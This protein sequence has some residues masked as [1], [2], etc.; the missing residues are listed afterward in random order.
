MFKTSGRQLLVYSATF[1]IY[2][3]T[4]IIR[5]KRVRG[6]GGGGGGGGS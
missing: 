4:F 2:T 3:A 6:C 1:V 5:K